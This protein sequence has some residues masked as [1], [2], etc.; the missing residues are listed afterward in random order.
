[1]K[2][3]NDYNG[4]VMSL[5]AGIVTSFLPCKIPYIYDIMFRL[6]IALYLEGEQ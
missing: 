4:I 3:Y 6:S 5:F 2:I 1:M